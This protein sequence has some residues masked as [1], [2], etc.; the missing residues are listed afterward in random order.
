ME[1]EQQ[2]T[3]LEFVPIL[4]HLPEIYHDNNGEVKQ[5]HE[6]RFKN[7][8]DRFKQIYGVVPKYFCRAPG[9]VNIIGEHI[10]YCGYSVLPA[11][12]EQDFVMAYVLNEADE[13]E[14]NNIDKDQ[15][16]AEKISTDPFQKFKEGPHWINYF[17]CGYKAV[18]AIDEKYYSQVTKPRGLKIMIDSLVPPA[19]GVSS[20]SAF[21][22]CASIV[23]LHANGLETKIPKGDL[24]KLCVLAERMAGTACGGM[25]QTIS[26]FAEKNQAKL[27]E[28][29]PTLK[30]IDV[31]IPASVVLAIGN[32][33]TPS[34]KLLTLGT[35][36]NKRVVECRFALLI[37]ALRTGDISH[38]KEQK[39]KNFYEFQKHLGYSYQQMLE[40][41]S[42]HLQKG[43]YTPDKVKKE[44]G[45]DDLTDLL[46]DIPYANEVISQ[47][48]QFHLFE[49]AYHVFGEAS[50][51]YEF[52]ELCDDETLDEAVKV[53]KL[54]QLMNDSHKSCRDLYDCS[55]PELDEIT[56]LS[57]DSGA[58]GSR[59]TG[60]GWGGCS[61]SL[62]PKDNLEQFLDKVFTYY[63]KEREPGYQLWITDDLERYLFATQPGKGACILDPQYCLWM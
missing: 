18:L 52:K 34:P 37:L 29:N 53:Q 17:L 54:G 38:A 24:S 43:G 28:F 35:R 15:Y 14:L 36:Y 41:V 58:L 48:Y 23:A 9:R 49:R 40:L 44:L 1:S 45:I 51:V 50:R 62:I 30:A 31:K 4:N 5:K 3:N 61:V 12:I 60:A 13:I 26:I 21:T 7:L 10:D 22:V 46:K 20:S 11:A 16:P 39:F 32:S 6:G 63:T 2:D 47:N 59:L 56:Q 33:L 57:R 55:S 19:A 27:I 8:K 25:D 42:S